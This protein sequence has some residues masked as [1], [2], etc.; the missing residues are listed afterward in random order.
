MSTPAH[1]PPDEDD[2]PLFAY[3]VLL[4]L[5]PLLVFQVVPSQDGPAHVDTANV[6]RR[7]LEDDGDLYRR[8]YALNPVPPPNFLGHLLMAGLLYLVPAIVAEKLLV[9]LCVALLPLSARYA[10]A[11]VHPSSRGLAFLAFPFTLS[12]LLH[13]GFYN[14]CLSLSL[15]LFTVG[16]W[17][18]RAPAGGTGFTVKLGG[19][20][21]LLCTAHLLS[22]ATALA[23]IAVQG[24]WL[25]A[26]DLRSV[27]AQPAT[28]IARW[29]RQ[30]APTVLALLPALGLAGVFLAVNHGRRFVTSAGE[31]WDGLRTLGTLVTFDDRE[32]ILTTALVWVFALLTA[33]GLW[34]R[35]RHGGWT[36]SDGFLAAAV[37]LLAVYFWAPTQAAGGAYVAERLQLFPFLV[38]LLWL[39]GLPLAEW[40]RRA[41]RTAGVL[42]AT[43]LVAL[44]MASYGRVQDAL[45]EYLSARDWLKPGS[46]V[47]TLSYLRRPE[48]P[49][50]RQSAPGIDVFAHTVGY[51]AADRDLMDLG[52]YHGRVGHFPFVFRPDRDPYDTVGWQVFTMALTTPPCID[53]LRYPERTGE[54]LDYVLVW[55]FPSADRTDDCTRGIRDQLRLGYQ[56]VHRSATGLMRVYRRK[57]RSE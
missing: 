6:L 51:L 55:G 26:L 46:T 7:Y 34:K 14:L 25:A 24:V 29:L 3:L 53:F 27:S 1:D 13:M 12:W 44:H 49:E 35:V 15:F 50:R 30:A 8:Y 10:L 21:L 19:L 40:L 38:L 33:W 37:V 11:A 36:R 18:R 31:R 28:R 16:F 23:V 17:L 42:I 57:D 4:H 9:G 32:R 22:L 2:R 52:N 20:A 43:G 41:A 48:S 45:A 5:V 39:G 56:A 54:A 47:L